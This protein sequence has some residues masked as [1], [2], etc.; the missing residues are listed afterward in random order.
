M[1]RVGILQ[2]DVHRA[3]VIV[4]VE[5]FGDP[6]RTNADQLII[7]Q[8][9]Y[10]ALRQSFAWAGID[11]AA[12]VTEDR[13]DGALILVPPEVP[14][15][16]LVT[17]V[18]ARLAQ[19][20]ATHNADRGQ[21]QEKIRLRM[22]LHAGEMHQDAHGW[23][24]VSVNRAFRLIDAP[25]CRAALRDSSGVLALIVSD[26]FYDEVV[27]H[28][29]AAAPAR[30]RQVYVVAKET[31]MAAWV[32]VLD[33]AEAVSQETSGQMVPAVAASAQPL[34]LSPA[35]PAVR[36]SLPPDVAAFTGRDEEL[37]R[38][39]PHVAQA[40]ATGGVVA[41]HAIDGMPGVGKTALAVRAAH[42][43][44]AN[45]PERQLFIDLHAHTPGQEPLT[46]EDAL[47]G[48]LTA[49]GV[50]TRRLPDDL[51]G[52]TA[53]WRDQMAGQRVL[54]VLDNAADS[55]QVTPLLTG[56]DDCLVLVTSRRHLGDLPGR[57]V[58]VFLDV[59][60]P[61]T[62]REMFLRL[63]PRASESPPQAVAA[64]V[65]LAGFLP[66]AISL[67]ARVY[68]KHP[69]W[70]LAD[71]ERESQASLI[72]LK[73][74]KSSVGAA[75]DVSYQH[76]GPGPKR[77]LRRLG[78]HPGTTTDAYAAAALTGIPVHDASQHL[79]TLY[80]EG[81]LTEVGYRRYG[82]HDLIR[83]YAQDLA[84]ADAERDHGVGCL[85]DYYQRTATLAAAQLARQSRST[86]ALTVSATA[87]VAVPRLPDPP[88]ALTW[89]RTERANLLACVDYV[90]RT[91]QHTRV[92]ALTAALADLL[93]RDGPWNDAVTRHSNAVQAARQLRDRQGLANALNDLGAAHRLVGHYPAAAK[94]LQTALSIYRELADRQGEANAVNDLGAVQRQVGNYTDA[95]EA[96]QTALNIYRDLGDRH[97]EANSLND[98]GAVWYMVGR[99]Q[100]ATETLRAALAI[101][102]ELDDQQ[103]QGNALS[104]LG[105][106]R[107]LAGDYAGAAEAQQE[108]L[109]IAQSLGDRLGQANALHQLGDV[110][111]QTGDYHAAAQAQKAALH[112]YQDLSDRLGQA[113]TLAFLG[114]VRKLTGEYQ[115]AAENLQAALTIYRELGDRLGQGIALGN[116]GAVRRE[117]TDYQGAREVLDEALAIMR[118]IGDR[119]GETETLNEIGQLHR[120][121]GELNLAER[122][123]RQ[124]L[125]IARRIQ[126]DWDEAHALA[127][128]GRCAATAGDADSAD[129][130][131]R[132][133][134]QIFHRIGAAEAAGLA[135]EINTLSREDPPQE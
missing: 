62:A 66:L 81:L 25:A 106:V 24:G 35:S 15:S 92:V 18:P 105:T 91:G 39:A 122:C 9:M 93:R 11:W 74:E 37:R 104:N 38:I 63:A 113:N 26:W 40:T 115:D 73:A 133:G 36:Y 84:A 57:A 3:I 89:L 125:D 120:V 78:L 109:S 69:S 20:L 55:E 135:S 90:T 47:A 23:A 50:E 76:L 10:D 29:A 82:M 51:P 21:V 17:K 1:G 5:K 94:D 134:W 116:L 102:R 114:T 99:Y 13:G 68:A 95:T 22:A 28:H 33:A 48:L 6:A 58:P 75:F 34:A 2:A 100:D 4:D 97:G 123:H 65:E 43:L 101:Y 12:C 124:A 72:N 8:G 103:G 42:L 60:P 129:A 44:K 49:I 126:S 121:C 19:M 52:R 86:A 31:E 56:G 14:K 61:D 27:R 46:P 112:L 130:F 132:Q 7:R 107:R 41:I 117:T 59:L 83:R 30:F 96:L 131:L 70:T 127:G 67:L 87:P 64:L 71:L 32:R 85:L 111:R 77:L 79:D 110:R 98:L 54:I 118:T 119:G 45:F 53:L 128:L 80:S 108:A 16:W 88:R